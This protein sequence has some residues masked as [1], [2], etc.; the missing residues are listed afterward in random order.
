[1]I[2]LP[3]GLADLLRLWVHAST[4]YTGR[5]GGTHTMFHDSATGEP[6]TQQGLSDLIVGTLGF[7]LGQ[8][9]L[10]KV[11]A[12]GSGHLFATNFSNYASV[13]G[14]TNEL[15][16]QVQKKASG[17]MGTSLDKLKV[18]MHGGGAGIAGCRGCSTSLHHL[19]RA[20]G[21]G[22]HNLELVQACPP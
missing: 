7:I 16:R 6:F 3:T 2:P 1:M 20:R 12:R 8:A 13:E 10:P 15:L 14:P 18:G 17:L 11:D 21:G 9:G 19:G 4:R 5:Q 22:R